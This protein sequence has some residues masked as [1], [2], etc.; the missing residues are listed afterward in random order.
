MND[1]ATLS[2]PTTVVR[3][4]QVPA[5]IVEAGLGLNQRAIRNAASAMAHDQV[6]ARER[7]DV[8]RVVRRAVLRAQAS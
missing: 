3:A 5:L 8:N 2:V 1:Q 6:R 4:L 7:E